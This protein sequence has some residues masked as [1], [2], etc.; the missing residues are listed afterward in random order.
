MV[1]LDAL[2]CTP[3]KQKQFNEKNI[4]TAEDLI[5]RLPTTYY[6]FRVPKNTDT[7]Y[8]GE[9]AALVGAVESV[10]TKLAVTGAQMVT[11]D[12]RD[13]TSKKF[14][15][16]TYFNAS[17]MID[18]IP[19]GI[20]L[21]FGGSVQVRMFGSNR[22]ISM[23]NP[24]YVSANPAEMMKLIPQYRKIPK[25]S[26]SY[27]ND[28]LHKALQM[29]TMQEYLQP[30]VVEKAHLVPRDKLPYFI[31]MPRN[32]KEVQAS[33]RRLVFDD[34]FYFN[35]MLKSQQDSGATEVPQPL[36]FETCNLLEQYLDSLPFSLT[37][38]QLNAIEKMRAEGEEGRK[39]Q[40]LL[41]GDVGYGKTEV[42]KALA[43][44][45][46]ENGAQAVVLAPTT[47]L[48]EQHFKDFSDSFAQFGINVVLLANTM[49][50]KERTAVLKKILSGEAQ[51]IVG[52]HSVF[53]QDVEYRKIGSIVVDEEHRFGVEQREVL[54]KRAGNEAHRLSMSA[55]PIPRTLALSLYG[56]SIEVMELTTAP[57]HKKPI[58][59]LLKS[60]LSDIAPIIYDQLKQKHQCY[61]VCPLIQQGDSEKTKNLDSVD[62][63]YKEYTAEFSR[64]GYKIGKIT[65]KMKKEEASAVLEEFV[66]GNIDILIAT[67]IVEVGVNVPNATVMILNNAERYGLAQIHQLRGRV[68]RGSA[69][70][71]C[72]LLY[73]GKVQE[74]IDR[75]TFMCNTTNGFEIARKDLGRRGAGNI[76]GIAQTGDS[77]YLTLIMGFPKFNDYIR[78]LVN[79]LYSDPVS[80]EY[81]LRQLHSRYESETEEEKLERKVVKKGGKR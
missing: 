5:T 41:Q 15:H 7:V 65:G 44:M 25:M 8:D 53:S 46:V 23:I 72:I 66:A 17:Y 27:Y 75:L 33:E 70:G 19:G 73:N 11:F 47:V 32:E 26:V 61:V 22:Y 76:I 1:S 68:G 36:K 14:F 21:F 13:G 29:T 58:T 74:V 63:A 52:T 71:I 37:T 49:K 51:V 50:K 9:V 42:A 34:L 69:E 38:D 30:E 54:N 6:D 60:S 57:A 39:I 81:Y 3:T 18:K 20:P 78:N 59:T 2:G 64:Y 16:V 67:T 80:R 10:K 55:T 77:K 56:D 4:Y 24:P 45:T 35:F 79:Y 12:V 48:A 40:A 31:H 28:T 43:L 62:E